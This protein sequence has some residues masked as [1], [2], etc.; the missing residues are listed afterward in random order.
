MKHYEMGTK[1]SKYASK[2]IVVV[3]IS[4]VPSLEKKNGLPHCQAEQIESDHKEFTIEILGK[5]LIKIRALFCSNES[6]SPFLNGPCNGSRVLIENIQNDVVYIYG[7]DE[8]ILDYYL[9]FFL[10]N[11]QVSYFESLYF[12]KLPLVILNYKKTTDNLAK[13]VLNLQNGKED[14]LGWSS[15]GLGQLIRSCQP[16]R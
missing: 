1:T 10:F 9:L 4:S 16:Y 12:Q 3:L 11:N 2:E 13:V 15:L 8:L 14:T 5:K 7:N 6:Q